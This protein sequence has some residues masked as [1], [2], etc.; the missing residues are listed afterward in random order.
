MNE[1]VADANGCAVL[2]AKEMECP[3][4]IQIDPI[5]SGPR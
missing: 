2:Y 4:A 3:H 1:Q 5:I